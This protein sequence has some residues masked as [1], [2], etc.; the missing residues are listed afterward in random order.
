MQ[1]SDTKGERT[2]RQILDAALRSFGERGYEATTMRQIAEAAGC[3]PG[4]AYRYFRRKE[5]LGLALYGELARE[6][7]LR[8]RELPPATVAERFEAA[9]KAKLEVVAPHRAAIAALFAAMIT[10]DD[11]L[12]VIGPATAPVRDSVAR[13]FRDV[14]AGASD[15]PVEGHAEIAQLLQV[16]HLAVLLVWLLDKR[17]GRSTAAALGA[18]T[19]AIRAASPWLGS[20]AARTFVER[21]VAALG[22]IFQ[23]PEEN[24]P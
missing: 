10:G 6:L 11:E 8:A 21:A 19:A 7:E 13:V 3:S 24:Q 9:M 20:A 16:A 22:A 5:E 23:T 15:R 17:G 4:L 2:R 18:V 1:P 12:S 14:V